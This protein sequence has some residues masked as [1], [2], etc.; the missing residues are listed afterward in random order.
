MAGIVTAVRRRQAELTGQVQGRQRVEVR[1][2]SATA[3]LIDQIATTLGVSQSAF[4]TVAAAYFAAQVWTVAGIDREAARQKI[5]A[6]L[7]EARGLL[8]RGAR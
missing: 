3:A 1:T 4:V 6:V 7:D 2:S 8:E 5:L